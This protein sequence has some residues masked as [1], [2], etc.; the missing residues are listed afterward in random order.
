MLT[1]AFIDRPLVARRNLA[2][3]GA[4]K[5]SS[6]FSGDCYSFVLSLTLS[7]FDLTCKWSF[8]QYTTPWPF[9]PLGWSLYRFLKTIVF[10]SFPQPFCCPS[11]WLPTPQ[12]GGMLKSNRPAVKIPIPTTWVTV[13]S[14]G[15]SMSW[16]L[17]RSWLL[18]VLDYLLKLVIRHHLLRHALV[19]TSQWV[20]LSRS[21]TVSLHGHD[22]IFSSLF[23]SGSICICI[24][25]NC[26]SNNGK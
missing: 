12:D 24:Y 25:C 1:H 15:H 16:C 14:A 4:H 11:P 26:D 18:S 5:K 2:Q 13:F 3:F 19:I 20:M 6:N 22:H 10:F 21:N 17:V 7:C 9:R 8:G 23:A